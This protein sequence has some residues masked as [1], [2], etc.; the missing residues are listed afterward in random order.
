MTTLHPTSIFTKGEKL[1]SDYFT[2]NAFLT[3][4]LARDKNNNFAMGSVTFEPKARTHW[5]THP[6]GQIL[7]VIEGEGLYQEKGQPARSIKKG[8]V[9]SIPE[10]VEHWHG[11]SAYNKM[12]HIAITNYEGEQNVVWL[13]PVSE[14][15]YNAANKK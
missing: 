3:S 8:D 15:D 2:G 1:S 4:L 12:I 7:V 6:K 14:A 10:K 13:E 5:H 9:I 11:A